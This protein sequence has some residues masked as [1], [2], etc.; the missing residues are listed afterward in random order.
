MVLLLSTMV[1]STCLCFLFAGWLQNHR[2]IIQFVYRDEM[3]PLLLMVYDDL[4]IEDFLKF[5]P[6]GIYLVSHPALNSK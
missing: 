1:I 2:S 5:R 6:D 3:K 4:C